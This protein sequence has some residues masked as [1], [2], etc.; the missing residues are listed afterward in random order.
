MKKSVTDYKTKNRESEKVCLSVKSYSDF[1]V[2]SER[3]GIEDEISVMETS[4]GQSKSQDAS[5][6]SEFHHPMFGYVH[7]TGWRMRTN[8]RLIKNEVMWKMNTKTEKTFLANVCV[9]LL[10]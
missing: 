10:R 2:H 5:L 8:K 7:F 9:S 4:R 1:L 6:F 3:A